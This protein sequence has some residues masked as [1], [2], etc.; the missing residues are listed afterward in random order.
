MLVAGAVLQVTLAPHLTLAG[1]FPNLV[2]VV[3]AGW[4][5]ISGTR[6]G[7]QWAIAGGLLLDLLS[8]GPLGL[9]ALALATSAYA[10]GFLQRSYAPDPLVLPAAAGALAALVYNLVLVT[11]VELFG[12]RQLLGAV[13]SHWVLPSTLYDAFLAPIAVLLLAHLDHRLPRRQSV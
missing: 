9:H 7:I 5:L 10:A 12:S 13:L 8:P 3:V 11:A 1:V 2:L 4:T 6:A